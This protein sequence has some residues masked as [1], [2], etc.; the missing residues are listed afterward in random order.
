GAFAFLRHSAELDESVLVEAK[1]D[2]LAHREIA[3]FVLLGDPVLA[4]HREIL[5]ASRMKLADLLRVFVTQRAHSI[6]RREAPCAPA[7]VWCPGPSLRPNSV[8]GLCARMPK[9]PATTTVGSESAWRSGETAS[10][11][12]STPGSNSTTTSP[13]PASRPAST[14][15]AKPSGGFS[16][17]TRK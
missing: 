12:S 8:R 9:A 14:A 11:S 15:A 5:L 17:T 2:A 4:A 13:A 1:V 10:P 7:S 6:C 3:P 16:D